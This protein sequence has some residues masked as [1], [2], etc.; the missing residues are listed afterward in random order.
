[1]RWWRVG[2]SFGPYGTFL[3]LNIPFLNWTEMSSI[4]NFHRD[5]N[6]EMYFW[7]PSCFS[8]HYNPVPITTSIIRA[9]FPLGQVLKEPSSRFG[10]HV[11]QHV[12]RQS[13]NA[14]ANSCPMRRPRLHLYLLNLLS[15]SLTFSNLVAPKGSVFLLFSTETSRNRRHPPIPAVTASWRRKDV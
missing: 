5:S 9:Q 7:P 2:D 13:A 10:K 14:S 4:E 12:G 11:G 8:C 1:M 3:M 15:W 6:Y